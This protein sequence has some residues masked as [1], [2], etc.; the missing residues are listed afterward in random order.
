[1]EVNGFPVALAGVSALHGQTIG[2]GAKMKGV[3][4]GV[5]I[6]PMAFPG[7]Q[8]RRLERAAK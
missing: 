1:M 3:L 7:F 8:R 5:G 4:R 6:F 2:A